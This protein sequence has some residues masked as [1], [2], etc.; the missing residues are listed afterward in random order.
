MKKS[1]LKKK[2]FIFLIMVIVLTLIFFLGMQ[3]GINKASNEE[4]TITTISEIEV[5]NRTIQKTLT[6]SGQIESAKTE[7]LELNTSKYFNTMCVETDDTVEEGDNILEYT[8]GTYLTAPYNCIITSYNVPENGNLCDDENYIEVQ[9]LDELQ[10]SLS[11]NESEINS[12]KEEQEVNITL[13]ADENKEYTGKIA[14]IDS[15]GTYSSGGSTFAA[16]VEFEND[17]NIK[18]G[19]TAS[20]EVILEEVENVIAVPIAAVQVS[21]D[22]KYVIVVKEDGTTENINVETGISD[23]NYV[24]IKSGLNGDETIQLIETTTTNNI[25]SSQGNSRQNGMM[26]R[27]GDSM[28][29]DMQSGGGRG[30]MSEN[31]GTPPDMKN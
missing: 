1:K 7:K 31:M 9:S 14:T 26:Q 6:S 24:Q 17:G 20:C 11:I 19:M 29:Q 25:Q 4:K 15:V 13:T 5:E 3:M 22:S 8:D 2:I 18:I 30:Q 27:G 21:D 16:K 28:P 10:I 23:D 12:V